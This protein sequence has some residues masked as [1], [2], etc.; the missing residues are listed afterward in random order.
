MI[1]FDKSHHKANEVEMQEWRRLVIE[2]LALYFN[3]KS[4]YDE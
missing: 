3:D 1:S 4:H 2:K